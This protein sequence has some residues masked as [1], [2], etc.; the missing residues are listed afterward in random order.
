MHRSQ[1]E[2]QN[3]CTGRKLK[4]R[5]YACLEMKHT[6]YAHVLNGNIELMH[7]FKLKYGANAQVSN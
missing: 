2:A 1:N 5:A 7:R 4:H 3:L 6:T